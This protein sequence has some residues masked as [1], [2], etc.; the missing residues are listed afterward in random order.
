MKK[1]LEEISKKAESIGS[2]INNPNFVERAPKELVE[3]EKKQHEELMAEM[4]SLQKQIKEL[5]NLHN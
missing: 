2:R 1:K 5:Q 4:S 3:K